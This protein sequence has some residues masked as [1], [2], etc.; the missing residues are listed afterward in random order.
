VRQRVLQTV[1]QLVRVHVAQPVLHVRVDQQL[2][3]AQHLAAQ[4]ERVAEPRLLPLLG[5]QRLDRLEVEVV[6]EVQVVEPLAH[7]QQVEHVVALAADLE[8]RLDPVELR[9][10]EELG[11]PQ[12]LHQR[13]LLARHRRARVQRRQH[14]PLEQLL[15]RDAHLHRV[16][17]GAALGEPRGD[18]R[19]VHR[20]AGAAGAG[21][22]RRRGP[23][24]RD[25]RGGRRR[26]E[27]E[28]LEQRRRHRRRKDKRRRVRGRGGGRRGRRGVSKVVGSRRSQQLGLGLLGEERRGRRRRRRLEGVEAV[29]L[30]LSPRRRRRGASPPFPAVA[31]LFLPAPVRRD[32]VQ[33]GIEVEGREV[34]IVSL[35]IHQRGNVV[36]RDC[37]LARPRGVQVRER[38]LVLGADRRVAH[39]QLV[40]VVELVP[41][42]VTPVA[43]AEQRL[44]LGPPRD[45]DV[46]RL[47]RRKRVAVEEVEVVRVDRV[48][49]QLT[50]QAVERREHVEREAPRPVRG[51]IDDAA[52]AAAG[53]RVVPQG[54]DPVVEPARDLA[55]LGLVELHLDGL[56]RVDVEQVVR[57]V[58]RGLLVVK[59]REAHALEVAAV[60][61]LAAHH[62]PHRAPLRDVDRLDHA[63]HL[64]DKGDRASDVVQ[65]AHV[66]D[67]LP[68]HRHVLQELED[69][70]RDE[71]ECPQVD[72]AVGLELAR[73]HVA[74][75]ADDLAHVLR[76]HVLLGGRGGGGGAAAGELAAGGE[77]PGVEGDPFLG[78]GLLSEKVEGGKNKR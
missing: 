37:D 10:L 71:L 49:Q 62:D 56:E 60:A 65:G 19:D 33:Q 58:E 52:A 76:G 30:H 40:D 36:R 15:I 55:V 8:P 48:R 1:S 47:G 20:P 17:S 41:V 5:R 7:D 35:D 25:A 61:L 57:V 2:R 29:G 16:A 9:G 67:L 27:R 13:A 23:E 54:A 77:A 22:E 74:V 28:G 11:R 6:V 51:A 53:A 39:H 21:V 38:D 78:L 12:R 31:S 68:G 72:A 50:A 42:V 66:P 26:R 14:R 46:E 75:V 44:E 18:K 34:G 24:E 43:V 63:R 59:R 45:R 70:V 73:G 64:V 69:G 32:R 3:Q 4:V